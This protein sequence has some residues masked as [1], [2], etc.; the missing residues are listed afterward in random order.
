MPGPF[1]LQHPIGEGGFGQVWAAVHRRSGLEVALKVVH[2][3]P[4]ALAR[5]VEAVAGLDHPRIVWILD[6]GVS[7]DEDGLPVGTPW[8]AMQRAAGTLADHVQ[9]PW[10]RQ[11]TALV[12]LLQ[13]LAH[14][15][16]RGIVHLDIKPTN[17]LV[18]CRR[19]PSDPLG[20][21]VDGVCLADF[22]IAR[23]V[24]S[25]EG[26]TAGTPH[27]MAPEQRSGAA[28]GPWTDL[29][30]VGCLA[31]TLATGAPPSDIA[32]TLPS[33]VPSGWLDWLLAL[34]AS[35]PADRFPG[36]AAA[37]AGLLELGPPVGASVTP[38]LGLELGDLTTC[39]VFVPAP[40]TID[41]LPEPSQSPP[42][43]SRARRPL[44]PIPAS[45][46]QTSAMWPAAPVVDAGLGLL[47]LREP[48]FVGREDARDRL[49]ADLGDVARRAAAHTVV[50]R[51]PSGV[52]VSRLGTWLSER[53][54]EVGSATV[55]AGSRLVD[56]LQQWAHHPRS[57]LPD[58]VRS[59]LAEGS[60][61][62]GVVREVLHDAA[63]AGPVLVWIDD[64]PA[65]EGTLAHV[66]R[67][68]DGQDVDPVPVLWVLGAREED[69]HDAATLQT[70]T[71]RADV[72]LIEVG[73]LP[74]S[75]HE[76]LV[77]EALHLDISVSLEV[78]HR[79]SGH[80]GFAVSLLRE[81]VADGSLVPG[82]DGFVLR[83]GASMTPSSDQVHSWRRRLDAVAPGSAARRALW[84]TAILGGEVERSQL[85]QTCPDVDAEA[86]YSDL[87]RSGL[88]SSS[89]SRITLR[90][91]G[92]R[93]VLEFEAD[94]A[95]AAKGLHHIALQLRPHR[96]DDPAGL[97]RRARHADGTGDAELAL[98]CW[99][100][101]GSAWRK[102]GSFRNKQRAARTAWQRATDLALPP[103]DRRHGRALG[104]VVHSVLKGQGHP[105]HIAQCEA[106]V[107]ASVQNEW[108]DLEFEGR[109]FLGITLLRTDRREEAL[110]EIER[111]GAVAATAEI[112]DRAV[113]A[114]SQLGHALAN[115]GRLEP[116]A[117][118]FERCIEVA[119][120]L[121]DPAW[122]TVRGHCGLSRVAKSQG[123]LDLAL[124][125]AEAAVA[126]SEG[127]NPQFGAFA[128]A[129]M[130]SAL[131]ALD[132][133]AEAEPW[134]RR[135]IDYARRVGST[136]DEGRYLAALAGILRDL[137]RRDEAEQQ[138]RR[139]LV[140]AER[141]GGARV[142]LRLELGILLMHRGDWSGVGA[143]VDT[144]HMTDSPGSIQQALVDL[145]R[146]GAELAAG[147]VEHVVE[148]VDAIRNTLDA[149]GF[150]SD[151]MVEV[152]RTVASLA[153]GDGAAAL[154]TLIA[155][156]QSRLDHG[157]HRQR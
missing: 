82:P 59:D 7:E 35:N 151:A 5:E 29:Y 64:A 105:E 67:H 77:H 9:M 125:H 70:L 76:I 138:V 115:R 137:D 42:T 101:A 98:D 90:N 25:T 52:G 27:F 63:A 49:W 12:G 134:V 146:L 22:G 11:L 30:A 126:A 147:P 26:P 112:W 153:T 155:S 3:D 78:A 148:R 62:V 23:H 73:P 92:L 66:S 121:D 122:G 79:T 108:P 128:D 80:P 60:P 61:S 1:D 75:D 157:T 81:L 135:S 46:D 44:R 132:R 16:A 117:S 38:S 129:V 100:D 139:A 149:G 124:T 91:A 133:P 54:Q 31:H 45:W 72:Q 89:T 102:R 150:A 127:T 85:R 69:S 88:A 24:R 86:L 109:M 34:L 110:A 95:G 136:S 116:A 96:L 14:A 106:L 131:L 58:W 32:P 37:V 99:L 141:V 103:S 87:V 84:L 40:D 48:A 51:G 156:Q 97:E 104:L 142:E 28:V 120:Q 145:L 68:L 93:D 55:L 17:V 130:G 8:F 57:D 71:A 123:D 144:T 47:G 83:K 154:R 6:H 152:A 65:D 113:A 94:E 4:N 74:E 33:G 53:A 20:H 10:S 13:G 118:W 107:R 114:W 119:P 36:A 111:A 143:A 140:L 43:T 50:L 2:A 15:H 56:A 18:G 19:H 41:T 21:P 39:A